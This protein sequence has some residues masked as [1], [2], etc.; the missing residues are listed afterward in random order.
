MLVS[1]LDSLSI[2]DNAASG[3]STVLVSLITMFS[4]MKILNELNQK[5]NVFTEKNVLYSFFD[6]EAYDYVGSG[7]TA[8]DLGTNGLIP[9]KLKNAE[10]PGI[11]DSEGNG[12]P[13]CRA[14]IKG[15]EQ[16]VVDPFLPQNRNEDDNFEDILSSSTYKKNI[17]SKI[18]LDKADEEDNLLSNIEIPFEVGFLQNLQSLSLCENK[19]KELPSSIAYLRNLKSLALHRNEL[20]ALPPEIVKLRS[21]YELSLR[22]NP[23]VVRF[24][25]DML[26]ELKNGETYNGH[27]VSCDSWM[28]V[29]L[30]EVICTSRD[31]DKFWRMNECYIKGSMIKYL[32]IPDEVIDIVKEEQKNTNV[33]RTNQ[34]KDGK[35]PAN[36]KNNKGGFKQTKRHYV[37]ATYIYKLEN[38]KVVNKPDPELI[39]TKQERIGK[40]SFGEVFKGIDNR[41]QQ[42]IAIKIIDL[43]EA[44]DEIE[45]IQQEIMVLSQC[46]SPFADIW[47]LGITAIELAKGEPPNSDLHPMRVLFLI[48]KNNPPQ[49]TGN[50]SKQ[51]KEFVEAC[52]NKDPENENEDFQNSI[53]LKNDDSP[54]KNQMSFK[55]SRSGKLNDSLCTSSS[56]ASSSSTSSTQEDERHYE[57]A[58]QGMDPE[59]IIESN[60]NEIV[61]SF[62]DM[63]LNEKLLRG[64]YAY[65]FEKPSAIQQR[66]ILPCIK[67]HDVIAQAQSGTGKTAT[68]SIAIL[69]KIDTEL[70]E[71]Q[72]LILAPT[73]ELANQMGVHVVSGTPGRVFDMINRGVLK[74][75]HIKLFVLDEADEMLSRGFKDQIYDRNLHDIETYYKT[76]I[77]EMPENESICVCKVHENSATYE[78][79]RIKKGDLILAVNE[80]S[81]KNHP[82]SIAATQGRRI[83]QG[84]QIIEINGQSVRDLNQKD[85]ANQINV[86]DGEIV[87]LLGRV[88]SFTSCIQDWCR[89]KMQTHLKTRTSTWSAYG[90]SKDS[91][92]QN[93]RPSLPVAKETPRQ[94]TVFDLKV[95]DSGF[96]ND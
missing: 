16:I 4:T 32:R 42:V 69:Q 84:D 18:L 33:M 34:K 80:Y 9:L 51:F 22:D 95:F 67:G 6:G 7:R 21:L 76:S 41:T 83:M 58:A 2:F 13:F 19:L 25:R 27:L 56:S 66:A 17:S 15:T 61:T 96:D 82:G 28:N 88:P 89:K 1:K 71:C 73:R 48:P 92:V 36:N 45:D 44:E 63:N 75:D 46:D 30:R 79:G 68:F 93:Q 85:V 8:Y 86:L 3:A 37:A 50:F 23:L 40:G 11:K 47:S 31:G 29:N 35:R 70:N 38:V 57:N 59:G 62:D 53:S 78:D 54:N 20:T 94:Y 49:L 60:W 43:E 5:N 64:I 90:N 39:F 87:L 81:F 55:S 26:V 72:A 12:C 91:K 10:L 52:L 14:E 24:V 74:T 65:G 77:E